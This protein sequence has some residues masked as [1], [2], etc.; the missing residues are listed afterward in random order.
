MAT[1][2]ESFVDERIQVILIFWQEREQK[3]TSYSTLTECIE[4]I[5]NNFD[6]YLVENN[7]MCHS[8]AYSLQDLIDFIQI[9]LSAMYCLIYEA[10]FG[11]FHCY[12]KLWIINKIYQYF[13]K[14]V[15]LA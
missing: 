2:P 5:C 13:C 11:G 7:S 4:S 12:D 9:K 15:G 3:C 10:E 8:I 14:E 6:I 1:T